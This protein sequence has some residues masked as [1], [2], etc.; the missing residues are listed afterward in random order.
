MTMTAMQRGERLVEALHHPQAYEHPVAAV[1]VIQTHTAW[2]LLTGEY[3]YKIK[4]PVAFGFLDFSTLEKRRHWCEEETRLNRRF[5]PDIYLG[6]TE[7]R[8]TFQQPHTGGS[9]PVLEY[10]V[11][12]RQ[13]PNKQLLSE[14][15]EHK[16]LE[17][18]HIDQ[19][20]EKIATFHQTTDHA[21]PDSNFGQPGRI[22]H[23]VCDNFL[24]LLP[25]L[26][27]DE[28]VGQLERIRQWINEQW[29]QLERHFAGRK[30]N[31]F[32]REC[33]GD[34]HLR[35]LTIID[36]D[37][38]PFDCIE[39]NA[40]LR[41]IDVMSE[42]AFLI[43]D[44]EEHGFPHFSH[45]FL[46][47]YLQITGD[48]EGLRVLHY[49]LVYRALV[50]AKVAILRRQQVPPQSQDYL[51]STADYQH[52]IQLALQHMD[53][54]PPVLFIT[55]GLSGSGKSTLGRALNHAKGI[56]QIRSDIERKRLS[57]LKVSERD[58]F[59]VD[60]GIYFS[61]RTEET[62]QRLA[63]LA[64]FVIEAGFSVLLDAT[65]LK[66]KH[67][68]LMR[69]VADKLQVRFLILHCVVPN[70]MLEQ[71]IQVRE[72]V[73]QDSSDATLEV[74]NAQRNKAEP[75][76]N[77][78]RKVTLTVDTSQEDYVQALLRKLPKRR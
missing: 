43:M 75:L 71:R 31:G 42:V 12:M 56:I 21:A 1:H 30:R 53:K 69:Q 14:L 38:T 52:Y 9:G 59:E 26:E 58:T 27:T 28:D 40:E 35:N 25:K 19:L 70:A 63:E 4:K 51:Q 66:E 77:D 49:Y 32:I 22:H 54:E 34:L 55:H 10:A 15:A 16:Q 45:Q 17:A 36:G 76:R 2:V 67:R 61:Q 41:W 18:S 8:G 78:E 50:R 47:G 5:A 74:L 13:F 39:F 7:I 20:I 3:A 57:G 37:I 62:Y 33:H 11:H 6:V 68:D 44:L 29:Q 72:E 73:G 60:A 23:W 48:Y 64:V 24:Y 65:F 46:N